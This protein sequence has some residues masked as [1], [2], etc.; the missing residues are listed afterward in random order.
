VA[1]DHFRPTRIIY[2]FLK[3]S[4]NISG[5]LET[6]PKA[7]ITYWVF[8]N[9][10]DAIIYIAKLMNNTLATIVFLWKW[11]QLYWDPI[12]PKCNGKSIQI[13][14]VTLI[15]TKDI[16]QM[17]ITKFQSSMTFFSCSKLPTSKSIQYVCTYCMLVKKVINS[18]G[19]EL[20]GSIVT[21]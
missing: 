1:E 18:V 21:W 11:C 2:L 14:G 7:P 19:K 15:E 5:N 3:I 20:V 17:Q 9:K 12:L 16:F 6:L 13:V 10:K 4:R 8:F